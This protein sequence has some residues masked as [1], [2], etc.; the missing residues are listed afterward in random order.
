[1]S[2]R[3]VQAADRALRM[4]VMPPGVSQVDLRLAEQFQKNSPEQNR[5]DARLAPFQIA[6][7]K[8]VADAVGKGASKEQL[9]AITESA[10]SNVVS[11]L[12]E[13]KIPTQKA[14]KPKDRER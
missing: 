13:G 9:A 4:Q 14:D 10:K 12:R 7:D 8:R 5:D 11:A 2:P 6:I 1:M 3:D